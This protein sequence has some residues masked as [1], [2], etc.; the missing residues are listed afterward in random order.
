MK[1]LKAHN[2]IEQNDTSFSKIFTNFSQSK[3]ITIE[4]LHLIWNLPICQ[5]LLPSDTHIPVNWE[6]AVKTIE[7][8]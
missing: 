6:S 7:K 5:K 1:Y 4:E 3:K 2:M 8:L